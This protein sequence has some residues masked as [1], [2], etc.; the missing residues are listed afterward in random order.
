MSGCFKSD[1]FSKDFIGLKTCSLASRIFICSSKL[2]RGRYPMGKNK[3]FKA[4]FQ[5]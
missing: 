2:E 4:G 1:S 3:R 5:S